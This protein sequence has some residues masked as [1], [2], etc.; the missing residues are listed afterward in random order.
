MMRDIPQPFRLPEAMPEY[1]VDRDARRADV[2]CGSCNLCCRT[3]MVPLSKEE[4][5]SGQYD[6]HYARITAPDGRH[7]GH[8]L[9]RRPTG[10]CVY[11]VDGRCSI[12]GRAPHV[13]QRFDCRELFRKSNRAGR[14]EMVSSGRMPKALYD[15]GREM[16]AKSKC[17]QTE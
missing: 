15:K 10:E 1:F 5:E 4:V 16:L 2:P 8:A 7:M 12:H 11:L 9:L 3:L 6:G 13:C 17:A 14:R